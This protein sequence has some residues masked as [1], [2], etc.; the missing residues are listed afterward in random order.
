MTVLAAVMAVL[1]LTTVVAGELTANRLIETLHKNHPEAMA[2]LEDHGASTGLA[3]SGW[4]ETLGRWRLT[5]SLVFRTPEWTKAD[6]ESMRRLRRYRVL[7][8]FLV[9]E[10]LLA[11]VLLPI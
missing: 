6:L 1:V 7:L 3:R 4:R 2:A 10:I 11:I 8:A 9:L 5:W